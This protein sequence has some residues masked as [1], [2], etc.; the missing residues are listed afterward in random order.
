MVRLELQ[1]SK[2]CFHSSG[3]FSWAVSFGC[4]LVRILF[5]CGLQPGS[6]LP[7]LAGAPGGVRCTAVLSEETVE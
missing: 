2:S 5:R 4:S 7:A 1:L 3:S 6:C